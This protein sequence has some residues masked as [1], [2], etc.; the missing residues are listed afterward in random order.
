[1]QG[2]SIFNYA[3]DESGSNPLR[4]LAEDGPF[5]EQTMSLEQFTSTF[6]SDEISTRWLVFRGQ[7][8]AAWELRPSLLRRHGMCRTAGNAISPSLLFEISKQIFDSKLKPYSPS[9]Q[10]TPYDEK[11]LALMQHFGYPTPLIDWTDNAKIALYFAF[12]DA[13]AGSDHV[14]VYVADVENIHDRLGIKKDRAKYVTDVEK[15]HQHLGFP[16]GNPVLIG[17][18]TTGIFL[19]QDDFWDLRISAQ[20]SAF[21]WHLEEKCLEH[22]VRQLPN[23]PYDSI[24]KPPILLAKIR[25]SV[26]SRPQAMQYLESNK[27]DKDHL[28]PNLD[29]ISERAH[30]ALVRTLSRHDS[31]TPRDQSSTREPPVLA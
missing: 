10:D 31:T 24:V 21:S 14:S 29:S 20:E 8:N 19:R 28:F 12:K 4:E 11:R 25:I 3:T 30:D 5:V 17:E 18:L 6:C 7:A 26:A 2:F 13:P 27:I 1:M 23:R 9:T 15:V 22:F 16:P